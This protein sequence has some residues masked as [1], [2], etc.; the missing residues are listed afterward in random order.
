MSRVRG[1]TLVELLVVIAIVGLLVSLLLPAVQQSRAAARRTQCASNMKQLGIAIL[2]FTDT[3]AGRFPFTGHQ[4]K[5]KTNSWVMTLAPFVESVDAIRICPDDEKGLDRMRADP[6]G[7][8]YVINE[9]VAVPT[10]KTSVTNINKCQQTYRLLM[11]FEGSELRD[12]YDPALLGE[13]VH[14]SQWYTKPFLAF[15][16]DGVWDN[17]HQ[18]IS[19][20]LHVDTANYL[21]GDGHVDTT[22]EI[23]VRQWVEQDI[24]ANQAD[25]ADPPKYNFALPV[26]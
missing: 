26:K 16:F 4:D 9:Y 18:E 2:Q 23:T 19:T 22:A 1:F 5:K 3:H 6:P 25:P 8:S 24:A 10:L 13:H 17:M 7:T 12:S 14:A 21:Y 11:I 15:G 20:G